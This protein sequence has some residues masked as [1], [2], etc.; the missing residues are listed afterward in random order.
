MENIEESKNKIKV[1]ALPSDNVGGVGYFRSTQ[2]HVA[3]S[4]L[5]GDEFEVTIDFEP[6]KHS[7]QWFE[8]FDII[9]YSKNLGNNFDIHKKIYDYLKP[10]GT[11]FVMDIDDY[12][13]LGTFHPMGLLNQKNK[14][15][16]RV[17]ENLRTADYVTTTTEIF[18]NEIRKHNKNVCVIPNAIDPEEE[19]FIPKP[20]SSNRLRFGIICGSSHEHD[21]NLLKGLTNS[22]GKEYLDKCQFVLC[23]FDLNG[24]IT[25]VDP[26]TG[27]KSYR[28]LKPTESVWFRYEQV[29]TDNY[30]LVSSEYRDFLLKFLPNAEYPN[31]ENEMYRR[32]WTKSIRTYATHYNNIDILLAPLKECDF[33][34]FKSQLKEE[35]AGF[36]HKG[37]IASNYGAYTIDLV[38]I[39]NK[40]GSINKDGNAL[41]VDINKNHKQWYKYITKLIKEPELVTMLQENLYNLVKDKYSI[42]EVTKT[43]ADFYKKIYEDKKANK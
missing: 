13:K 9:Q 29:L 26:Q 8:Q 7:F 21:I 15:N 33:N 23:G 34:K 42:K 25:Y 38:N 36:F 31:V 41:L 40:D 20:T 5:Y 19:Q 3:L 32:C 39:L 27:E 17:V 43:R 12:W 37:I 35:E 2:P 10:K 24:R 28:S 1:L 18:A 6:Y 14:T 4:K 30:K 11:I 22:L 16:E